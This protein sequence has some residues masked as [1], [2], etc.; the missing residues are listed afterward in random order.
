MHSEDIKAA[1]RKKGYSQ[2]AVAE[3]MNVSP[4]TVHNVIC[5]AC[6]SE[7]IARFI[8]SVIGIDRAELWPGRYAPVDDRLRKAY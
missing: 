2:K 6:K 4:T 5:G 1:L 8:S 3:R 7:R